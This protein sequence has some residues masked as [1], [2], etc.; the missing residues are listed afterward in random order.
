MKQVVLVL[1]GDKVSGAEK[2]LLKTF[3]M[4]SEDKDYAV[5]LF[6][7]RRLYK[8]VENR[9]KN[10]FDGLNSAFRSITL[11]GPSSFRSAWFIRLA[12]FLHGFLF[13]KN[14]FNSNRVTFY[15]ALVNP[16][17]FPVLFFF[18]KKYF[19][20]ILKPLK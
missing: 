17:F 12:W 1:G 13:L 8:D 15:L 2:R 18:Q 19:E 10:L 16:I 14:I 20:K 9:D 6:I 3:Y 7:E 11:V 4:L 5:D